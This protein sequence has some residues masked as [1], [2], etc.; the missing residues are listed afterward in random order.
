MELNYVESAEQARDLASESN[1]WTDT[2]NDALFFTVDANFFVLIPIL[3]FKIN[4]MTVG[5]ILVAFVFLTLLRKKDI[6]FFEF[7]SLV[8]L[9]LAG[10]KYRRRK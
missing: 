7:L 9:R 1:F 2:G 5:G 8:R 6:T 4:A 3:C 10:S